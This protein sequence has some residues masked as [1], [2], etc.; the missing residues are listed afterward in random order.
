MTEENI[1]V[2][3]QMETWPIEKLK[4][5]RHNPVEHSDKQK[6][7]LRALL[8]EVGFR[9]P[10]L[11]KE[12][13]G[14]IADGHLRLEIAEE[15]GID[16]LPVIPVD[17]LTDEQIKVL[18]IGV[19]KTAYDGN[20]DYDLLTKELNELEASNLPINL[21]GFDEKELGNIELFEDDFVRGGEKLVEE[22]EEEGDTNAT[23]SEKT[24]NPD[25][26]QADAGETQGGEESTETNSPTADPS[27][28]KH[29]LYV[30]YY[31]EPERFQR[32]KT[33]L[34]ELDLLYGGQRKHDLDP[35]AFEELIFNNE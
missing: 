19:Q 2:A 21:T 10:I 20:F 3:E 5:Y 14:E 1:E 33:A 13:D 16:E 35:D 12:E 23:K 11:A 29:Y 26:S 25:V 6:E 32:L 31:G 22:F 7:A 4:P 30:E 28:D 8:K 34:E 27:G 9:I 18:R 15:E 24:D 17:D